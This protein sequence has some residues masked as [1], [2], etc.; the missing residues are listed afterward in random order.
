MP[1][2][3][4]EPSKSVKIGNCKVTSLIDGGQIFNAYTDVARGAKK[5]LL[6][7]MFQF[8]NLKIDGHKW[9]TNGAEVVPGSKEQQEIMGIFISKKKEN[10]NFSVQ[11]ILDTHK[12]YTTGYG[13]KKRHYN[14]MEMIKYMK[15]NGIDVVPSPRGNQGGAVLDHVKVLIADGR[16]AVV[17]GMNMGSHSAANHDFGFLIEALPNAKHSEVDNLVNMFNTYFK[18]SWER[19][20]S[21]DLI[22]GPLSKEEQKFYMG[23]NKEIK[24]ENVE[25]M[26]I[27]G[28]LFD[29]P[30]DKNRYSEGR[31]DLMHCNPVENPKIKVLRTSPR[32]LEIIADKG[33]ESIREEMLNNFRTAKE[34]RGLN[35]V[36]TDK[37]AVEIIVER[38][39][40]GELDAKLIVESGILKQFAYCRKAYN[41]LKANGVPVRIYKSD[42]EIT[43]RLHA[44][45]NIFDRKKIVSGSFNM[46]AMA[47][48]Q[49]L[50]T[51]LR[52]DYK[53]YAK[54]INKEVENLLERVKE[55]EELV[56]IS[57]FV[58]RTFSYEELKKRKQIIGKVF[59]TLAEN[60]SATA[61]ID[62]KKH[63]FHKNQDSILST[64]H[65]YYAIAQERYK[66]K[67]RYKRG[68]NE[69]AI[70]FESP[71]IAKTLLKQFDKD[72]R[73]SKSDYD[74][75]KDKEFPMQK[76]KKVS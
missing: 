47:L 19:L 25:Y 68:N 32:E 41:L 75:W 65:G 76:P 58:E 48:N 23:L 60:D 53:L 15:E 24:E 11:Q 2:V 1:K 36:F 33:E 8:Q 38:Y 21:T 37:E 45:M 69:C 59:E 7:S 9:P 63:F 44:K 54:K 22:K 18:F 50:D 71:S 17:T 29:N 64:I 66:A 16:R 27:V 13:E 26:K 34:Y 3:M 57:P 73:Y 42:E 67:E 72:W 4:P 49:N 51:G 52:D 74:R 20:G 12:W 10:N 40:K 30:D 31:L 35:F 46:S 62:N 5:Y 6:N 14:N 55:H 39:K 61:T 70:V 28:K 56:G 43:Q